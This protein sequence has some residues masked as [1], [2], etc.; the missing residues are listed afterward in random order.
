MLALVVVASVAEAVNAV[1]LDHAVSNAKLKIYG[2]GAFSLDPDVTLDVIYFKAVLGDQVTSGVA[3][4][5]EDATW[6]RTLSVAPGTYSCFAHMFAKDAQGKTIEKFSN[7]IG[8]VVVA[9]P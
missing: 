3:E 8:G 2:D 6:D 7:V 5:Y 4:L 1:Y 9:G